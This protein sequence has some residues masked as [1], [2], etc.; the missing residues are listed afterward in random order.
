M[1]KDMY[2]KLNE[3]KDAVYT[4]D[5]IKL[6]TIYSDNLQDIDN[7]RDMS[8]LFIKSLYYACQYNRKFT[9]V[10]LSQAYFDIY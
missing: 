7:R 3:I 4:Q 8:D 2:K 6:K 5:H 10:F 9:I 1:N